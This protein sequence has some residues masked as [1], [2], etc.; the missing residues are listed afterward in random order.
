MSDFREMFPTMEDDVIEAVLRANDGAVDATIDQLLT[1][2]IDAGQ[3]EII[4]PVTHTVIVSRP[5]DK[6]NCWKNNFLIFQLKHL[7]WVLKRT[8]SVRRFF[9]VPITHIRIDELENI[10]NFTFKYF[11]CLMLTGNKI[12]NKVRFCYS[13]HMQPAVFQTSLCK[14]LVSAEPLLLAHR[15]LVKTKKSHISLLEKGKQ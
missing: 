14:C 15:L 8:V 9:W 5:L 4:D 7:L 11:A 10:H 6:S 3:E 13:S 12:T 1:M 2:S